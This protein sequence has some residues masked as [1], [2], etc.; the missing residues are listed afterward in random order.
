MLGK[1]KY[2]YIPKK[3]STDAILTSLSYAIKS[4]GAIDYRIIDNKAKGR[5]LYPSQ[6]SQKVIT[7]E[8]DK[9]KD[10]LERLAE[11]D[12]EVILFNDFDIE[13]DEIKKEFC[14]IVKDYDILLCINNVLD[15]ENSKSNISVLIDPDVHEL[16]DE[17]WD[18]VKEEILENLEDA[19]HKDTD[20]KE[21]SKLSSLLDLFGLDS[22]YSQK[23]DKSY[24][25]LDLLDMEEVDIK[26]QYSYSTKNSELNVSLTE[27][28]KILITCDDDY[29]VIP[30]EQ[31]QF[32]F[33]TL[34]KLIK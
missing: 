9:L 26:E 14:E 21:D 29:V 8:Y 3:K 10:L 16:E 17:E 32:L 27:D 33:E 18:S 25:N 12:V 15:L 23:S 6:L 31:V 2:T 19:K 28:D 5:R 7:C 13:L 20:D 24:D 1:I 11:D 34:Q 22:L 30:E 4:V